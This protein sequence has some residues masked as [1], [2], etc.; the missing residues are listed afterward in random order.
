[1]LLG[2]LRKYFL[3][4]LL[5]LALFILLL[6]NYVTSN[7]MKKW[8]PNDVAQM[9]KWKSQA[10]TYASKIKNKY[11]KTSPQYKKAFTLYIDAKSAID[12]WIASLKTELILGGDINKSE[13]YNS[14]LNDAALKSHA[15]IQYSEGLYTRGKGIA[16][17][18]ILGDLEETG[19]RIWREYKKVS[20][21]KKDKLK[22]ALDELRW[23]SFDE[24]K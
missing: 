3:L 11:S 22:A 4:N 1:M 15:F 16:S 19:M 9:T 2:I 18:I 23:K 10:E 6:P 21:D 5:L 13:S 14:L 17:L 8:L 24:I 20:E 7:E 12:A